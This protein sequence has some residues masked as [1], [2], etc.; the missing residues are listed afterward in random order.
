MYP[1]CIYRP[2]TLRFTPG[3]PALLASSASGFYAILCCWSIPTPYIMKLSTILPL[4]L[5]SN[6]AVC[7]TS[8]SLSMNSS[9]GGRSKLTQQY[10]NIMSIHNNNIRMMPPPG[11]PE[12]EVRYCIFLILSYVFLCVSCVCGDFVLVDDKGRSREIYL[13][14]YQCTF[15]DS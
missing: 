8:F 7:G 10:K 1:L 6:I 5:L 11:E 12:P 3:L 2:S 14:V 15:A 4:T 13:M 9:S